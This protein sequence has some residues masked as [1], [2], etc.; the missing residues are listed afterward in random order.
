MHMP[1]K[2]VKKKSQTVYAN[3]SKSQLA[4]IRTKLLNPGV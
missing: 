1:T 3:R 2:S 4:G